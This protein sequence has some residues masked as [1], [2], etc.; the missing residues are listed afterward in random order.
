MSNR[1]IFLASLV[2]LLA[3]AYG[4]LFS[5]PAPPVDP[6]WELA[7]AETIP[8]GAVTIRYAGTATLLI[9]DGETHW[10]TDG[11]F[12]RPGPVQTVLGE[13]EPDMDA[14]SFGLAAMEVDDLAAVIPLHSHYDHAMDAP[15]VARRTGA[16]VVEFLS[17]PGKTSGADYVAMMDMNVAAIVAALEAGS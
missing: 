2:M 7:P 15:E 12:T 11:W 9:S 8:E 6:A 17:Q 16:K 10:M 1:T 4:Y 13:I 5:Y 14:I 3:A